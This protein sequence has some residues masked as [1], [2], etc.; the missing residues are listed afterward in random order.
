M[1]ILSTSSGKMTQ[2]A[3]N[4]PHNTM[5]RNALLSCTSSFSFICIVSTCSLNYTYLTNRTKNYSSHTPQTLRAHITSTFLVVFT[6]SFLNYTHTYPTTSSRPRFL[7]RILFF[8]VRCC[9]WTYVLMRSPI[10]E[11]VLCGAGVA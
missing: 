9:T 3:T 4:R 8:E 7:F 1:I 5:F 10:L 2:M 6:H 11:S